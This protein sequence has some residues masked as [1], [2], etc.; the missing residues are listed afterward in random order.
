MTICSIFGNYK[1]WYY[2]V[3]LIFCCVYFKNH[4]LILESSSCLTNKTSSGCHHGNLVAPILQKAIS[5]H[6][7]LCGRPCLQYFPPSPRKVSVRYHFNPQLTKKE[8]KTRRDKSGRQRSDRF[9][10]FLTGIHTVESKVC[11]LRNT[12]AQLWGG[13]ETD[14]QFSCVCSSEHWDTDMKSNFRSYWCHVSVRVCVF[15]CVVYRHF[16][17][18]P[19]SSASAPP[20]HTS[21]TGPS[22]PHSPCTKTCSINRKYKILPQQCI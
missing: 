15:V 21:S 18:S 11:R 10:G 7:T 8:T 19:P 5:H 3:L 4:N 1:W 13:K 12:L 17:G 16:P 22:G 2:L 9:P 20:P 14:D 6:M